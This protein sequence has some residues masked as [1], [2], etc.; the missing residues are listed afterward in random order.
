MGAGGRARHQS[1]GEAVP[2]EV[3]QLSQLEREGRGGMDERR[4][5]P[6]PREV[7]APLLNSPFYLPLPLIYSLCESHGSSDELC[8]R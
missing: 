4:R 7:A 8:Q 3:A 5:P 6:A 2:N 1:F